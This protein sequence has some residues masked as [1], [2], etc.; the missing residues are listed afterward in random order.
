MFVEYQKNL[1]KKYVQ[2]FPK[3][4]RTIQDI[5]IAAAA[6]IDL[7]FTNTLRQPI[8]H[9]H[10]SLDLQVVLWIQTQS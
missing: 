4:S 3:T 6:R 10:T 1:I 9:M 5:Y 7:T 2:Q 8:V